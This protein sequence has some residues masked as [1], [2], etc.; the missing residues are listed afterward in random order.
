MINK[1]LR[2]V[3]ASN[4]MPNKVIIGGDGIAS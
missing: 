4:V 1:M 3:L 2:F